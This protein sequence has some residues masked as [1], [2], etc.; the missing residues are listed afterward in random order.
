MFQAHDWGKQMRNILILSAVLAVAAGAAHA[1]WAPIQKAGGI[2]PIPQI[3]Q[4]PK[5]PTFK[6]EQAANP[7]ADPWS[8]AGQ[9]ARQRQAARAEDARTN[10]P[11]SAEATAKRERAQ[12][13]HDAALLS[14]Y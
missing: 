14:P 1:Q 8:A 10:G 2:T 6:P 7:A 12:A 4:P 5:Q 11:F 13:K 9:A 3:P